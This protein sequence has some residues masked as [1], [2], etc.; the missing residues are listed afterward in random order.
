MTYGK[1]GSTEI[2]KVYLAIVLA[3]ILGALGFLGTGHL[4][5][6]RICRG[7]LLMVGG[8][9]VIVAGFLLMA[10]G[11]M[12]GMVIPPP[13]YPPVEPPAYGIVLMLAG[14]VLYLGYGVLWVWQIVDARAA[15]R[16]HNQRLSG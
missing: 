7:I 12:S 15:C 14:F 10:F 8:W 16:D 4:Y 3:V 6:G 1:R 11:G 9:V 13:G 5:A 2:K